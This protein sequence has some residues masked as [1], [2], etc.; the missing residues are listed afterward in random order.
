MDVIGQNGNDGE[1]YNES[2]I[3]GEMVRNHY[4]EDPHI[5]QDIDKTY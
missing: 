1:H 5:N 3:K 2:V 4:L